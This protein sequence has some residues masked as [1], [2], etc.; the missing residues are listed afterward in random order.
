M[1]LIQEMCVYPAR[2]R[3]RFRNVR[4]ASNQQR[5]LYDGLFAQTHRQE[6]FIVRFRQRQPL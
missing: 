6:A 2:Y 3:S 4:R 1:H 5:I